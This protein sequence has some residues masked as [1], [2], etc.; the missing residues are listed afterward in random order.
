MLRVSSIKKPFDI[1]IY[2]INTQNTNFDYLTFDDGKRLITI[3]HLNRINC[4][5]GFRLNHFLGDV[6]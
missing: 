4:H 2:E 1:R 6:V 5:I 3:Q